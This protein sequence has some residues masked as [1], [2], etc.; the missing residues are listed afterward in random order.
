LFANFDQ[1]RWERLRHDAELWWAGKLNRPLIQARLSGYEPK[2]PEPAIPHYDFEA[3]YDLSITPEQVVDRWDYD[4]SC[5]KFMGDG[6]PQA[7]PNFGPGV[8]AAFLGASLSNGEGTVWFDYPLQHEDIRKLRLAYSQESVWY[9]RIRG[10]TIAAGNRWKGKVQVGV[11]DLGG[12]L[13][14]LATFRGP[15]RLAMDLYDNPDEVKRLTWEIHQAWWQ[16]YLDFETILKPFN[17][18]STGWDGTFSSYRHCILQCDFA[19]MIGPQLFEEFV[20]PELAATASRLN[21]CFYH[22][23]GIGQLAHLDSLLQIPHIHGIQWVPG[24]GQADVSQ[25]PE[26]YRKIRRAGKLIHIFDFQCELGF[27][28]LDVLKDQLGSLNGILYVI[29]GD[30]SQETQVATLLDKFGVPA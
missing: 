25:W 10:I 7:W 2:R 1:C 19:Y 26:V 12:T 22:L 3:F 23:D 18:G 14:I 29:I 16:Y 9:K 30:K 4:L 21:T 15:E 8:V 13:D 28:L 11:T 20:K 6:Y 5:T 27:D 24:V 17:P